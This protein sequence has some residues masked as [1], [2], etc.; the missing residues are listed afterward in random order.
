MEPTFYILIFVGI[1]A[2]IIW[3]IKCIIN[4]ATNNPTLLG[5]IVSCLIGMLPFYLFLCWIGWMGEER[6]REE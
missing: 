3:I 4:S 6:H 2:F 1:I 5:I